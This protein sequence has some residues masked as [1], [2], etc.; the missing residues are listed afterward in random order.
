MDWSAA[1]P[2]RCEPARRRSAWIQ[3][4]HNVPR[5]ICNRTATTESRGAGP[6]LA[7]EGKGARCYRSALHAFRAGRDVVEGQGHRDH[8]VITHQADDIGDADMP[9]RLKRA[10]VEPL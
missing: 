9:E 1:R 8:C 7:S 3:S 6:T 4:F 5:I 2:T 10:V